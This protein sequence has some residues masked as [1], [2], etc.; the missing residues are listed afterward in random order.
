MECVMTIET[1]DSPRIVIIE[2]EVLLAMDLEMIAEEVGFE[3]VG[4]SGRLADAIRTID[5]SAP[6][7]CLVDLHLLDGPTGLDVARH[8]LGTTSA[9]VVFVT[10]NRSA[11]PDDL[12]GAYGVIGKPY[13]V[14]GMR[15]A[16]THLRKVIR[17]ERSEDVPTEL[18]AAS[19]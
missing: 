3:V 7:L 16:L 10:A 18:R 19:G 5:D 4:Q 17:G 13:T 6:D 9:M 11:L 2:D 12:A 1:Q 14:A 8:T 15:D